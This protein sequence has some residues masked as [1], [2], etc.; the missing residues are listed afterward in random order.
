VREDNNHLMI[1]PV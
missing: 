1:K